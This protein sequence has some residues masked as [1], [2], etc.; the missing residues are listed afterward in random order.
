[1]AR[2]LCG[3]WKQPVYYNFDQA[4]TQKILNTI[5]SNLHEAGFIVVAIT[6]DM[7]SRNMGLMSDLKVGYDKEC[8][9]NHPCDENS[10]IFVFYDAPHLLK[11]VRNHFLD[12]GFTINGK[13]FSK[14]CIEKLLST[15]NTEIT[16][17][18]KISQYH[19][20]VQGN[21]RQKVKP[22]AQLLSNTVAKAIE[23]C[24]SNGGISNFNWEECQK[25]IKLIN[26]WFD[27][28]NSKTKFG[29]CSGC[30]AFGT[31]INS[32]ISLLNE[33]TSQISVMIVGGKKAKSLLP[34]QKGIL[35]N[36]KSLIQIYNY[37]KSKYDIQY[38][39]T[40]HLNQDVLENFF[41]YIRGMGS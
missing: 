10:K 21:E 28:F 20:D 40:Y 36:N 33:V 7:G 27:L 26:D 5:I 8:Y 38:I 34:F 19:L 11:L 31:N 13:T 16:F 12:H 1:M 32:Q 39:M 17:A 9:F 22:A 2:G 29:T 18:N 41:S 25:F 35:L 4:M 3:Q 30:N 37:L 23:Y 6:C 24:G 15:S 14:A